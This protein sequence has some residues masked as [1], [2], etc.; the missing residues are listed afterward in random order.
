VRFLLCLCLFTVPELAN[1]T[2]LDFSELGMSGSIDVNGLHF[3]GVQ[4]GFNPGLALYNGVVGTSGTAEWSIDPVLRGPT[5][6]TLTLGFDVP[7]PILRFAIVLQSIFPIDSVDTGVNGGPAYT[8]VLSPGVSQAGS[9]APQPNGVYSEGQF[10]YSGVP[11]TSAAI[12]FYSG[13]DAG[14][15]PVTAFGLDNLT[16]GTPEPA[17]VW[18]VAAGLIAAGRNG[19]RRRQR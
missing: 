10:D 14:G 13:M 3:Q 8:V 1:A 5:T 15:M 18:L 11:I 9:T 2:T 16:Y 12:T 4:F 19:Y 7:T 17:T 6:G